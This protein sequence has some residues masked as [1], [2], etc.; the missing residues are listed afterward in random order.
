MGMGQFFIPDFQ[1]KVTVSCG[2]FCDSSV[3]K[4][5]FIGSVASFMAEEWTCT[6]QELGTF[7]LTYL[8]KVRRE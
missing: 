1:T 7:S 6:L 2:L 3:E 5:S 4:K 8:Y